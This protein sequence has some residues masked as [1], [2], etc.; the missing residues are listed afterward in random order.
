MKNVLFLLFGVI[1]VLFSIYSCAKDTE[2]FSTVS[3]QSVETRGGGDLLDLL[4]TACVPNSINIGAGCNDST[5]VDTVVITNHPMY[6]GCNFKLIYK[7]QECGGGS[8]KDVTIGDFQI[9]EH[10]CLQFSTDLNNN[11]NQSI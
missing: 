9:L 8:I 5:F 4:G 1:T 6:P 10:N 3:D 11:Y 7:R 2:K